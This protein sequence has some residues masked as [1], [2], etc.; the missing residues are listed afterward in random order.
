MIYVAEW[1]NLLV[2]LKSGVGVR[3]L[4]GDMSQPE[5]SLKAILL[6]EKEV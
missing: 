2:F 3:I 4:G 5:F 1:Q 6:Y